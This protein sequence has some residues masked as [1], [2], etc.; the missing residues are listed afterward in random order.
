M[1]LKIFDNVDFSCRNGENLPCAIGWNN[2]CT[3]LPAIHQVAKQSLILSTK[4]L[5]TSTANLS[6]QYNFQ[7]NLCPHSLDSPPTAI[8]FH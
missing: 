5:F 6:R 1:I 7:R 2:C 3:L 4:R 8:R